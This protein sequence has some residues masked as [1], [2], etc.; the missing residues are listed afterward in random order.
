MRNYPFIIL[1]ILLLLCY[2]PSGCNPDDSTLT[3]QCPLDSM[4]FTLMPEDLV[5]VDN[6]KDISAQYTDPTTRYGHG[7]LGDQIE[8]GGLLVNKDSKKYYV[9]LEEE[10][11]FEDLQPRLADVDLDGELEIIT[12]RTAL[13]KGASVAIYKIVNEGLV[14]WAESNFIGTANR[15]LNIAA[16]SDLDDDGK[17]EIAWVQTPHIG[18]ILRIFRVDNGELKFV[19]DM[20]GVSN[21][22]LNSRNLCLSVLTDTQGEKR[23]HLPTDSFEE[24]VEFEFSDN[25]ITES[26]RSNIVVDSTVP[27]YEQLGLVGTKVDA[28]CIIV[29]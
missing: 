11:V 1:A 23:L 7:V 19:D 24:V 10:F 13:T 12:I 28:S 27:L 2:L 6:S 26:S 5:A 22:K 15:W 14:L 8:A 3:D 25:K 4:V 29:R 18:G 21:H 17:V 9:L 16:I 20:V